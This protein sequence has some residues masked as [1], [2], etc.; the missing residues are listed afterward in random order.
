[1]LAMLNAFPGQEVQVATEPRLREQDFGN[2]QHSVDMDQVFKERQKFGRFYYRFPNGEAGTDV[3][4]RISEFID[5]FFTALHREEYSTKAVDNVV[6]VTHGLTMRIFC[7]SY[8]RWTVFEFEK[9]WNPSNC[10]NWVLEKQPSGQYRL[11]GRWL[12]GRLQPINFGAN[13]SYPLFPHMCEPL[14]ARLIVPGS[15]ETLDGIQLAHFRASGRGHRGL[16]GVQG[17]LE[18]A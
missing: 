12:D 2:F 13:Q 18:E 14:G 17:P 5:Y 16:E 9:V 1:L 4:D 10:E 6:L 11:A 3:Y 7:M 15:E 8:F